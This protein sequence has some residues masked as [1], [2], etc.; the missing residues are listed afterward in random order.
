MTEPTLFDAPAVGELFDTRPYEAPRAPRAP[1]PAEPG[2]PCP[3]CGASA[4]CPC[5][6]RGHRAETLPDARPFHLYRCK[7]R[8]SDGRCAGVVALEVRDRGR[9]QEVKYPDGGWHALS[10]VYAVGSGVALPCPE[11]GHAGYWDGGPV[12]GTYSPDRECDS[13]CTGARGPDCEC[14]CGGA[15]HGRGRLL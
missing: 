12:T 9:W 11:C 5:D 14:Q 3:V 4:L 8:R 15:N 6:E 10:D 7:V 1:V 13:R 2:L